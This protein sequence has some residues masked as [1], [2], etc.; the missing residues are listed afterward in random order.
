MES[1]EVLRALK[2][3]LI[4]YIGYLAV[5]ELSNPHSIFGKS[6]WLILIA[7]FAVAAT[8]IFGSFFR[9]GTN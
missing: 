7:V 2:I 4:I 8:F 5:N 9:S 1:R 3:V 6:M